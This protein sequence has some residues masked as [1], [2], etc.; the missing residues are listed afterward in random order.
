M[1]W[2]WRRRRRWNPYYNYRR[3]TR[4]RLY[5]R[6]RPRRI[7]RRKY[8]RYRV[9][10]FQIPKR[11]LKKIT[12]NEWQPK[13][14]K[15]CNIKGFMC[16]FQCA[17]GRESFNY[18]QYMKSTT[19]E[20]WPGGGGWSIM[21]YNLG[22]LW[23]QRELLHNHWTKSNE[24]LPLV[25]Y[26]GV[27]FTFYREDTVDYIVHWRL[28]YPMTDTVQEHIIAQPS[29]TYLMRNRLIVASKR[30]KPRSKPYIKKRLYPPAQMKSGWYFQRDICNIGFLLLTAT[31]ISLDRWFLNPF[32]QSDSITLYALNTRNF[33]SRNFQLTGTTNYYVPR[34]GYYL[35][36]S[37]NGNLNPAEI[38]RKELIYLGNTMDYTPGTMGSK[39]ADEFVSKPKMGNPF[40]HEYINGD[41]QVLVSNKDPKVLFNE[42]NSDDAKAEQRLTIQTNPTIIPVRYTPSKDTGE[43]NITYILKNTRQEE[44]WEPPQ[45]TNLI[46]QGYP[47]W[48]QLWGWFD[49]Q[50]KLKIA[51]QIDYNYIA[52]TRTNFFDEKLPAYVLLDTAFRRGTDPYY[53]GDEE[54]TNLS[55]SNRQHFYPKIMYQQDSYNTICQT[56]PG[57]VKMGNTSIE[58]KCKYNFHLKW[59]GC[60]AK[61]ETIKDPCEQPKYTI[62]NNQLQTIQMQ[63]PTT[64]P[65]HFLYE[66]DERRHELTKTAIERLKKDSQTETTCFYPT[67]TTLLDP[68]VKTISKFEELL[69][70]INQETDSEE[71]KTSLQEQL[72]K[73]HEQQL[74]LKH[75]IKQMLHRLRELE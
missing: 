54:H 63:S 27:T 23:E 60:P 57:V 67:E 21:I 71:E 2:I 36:A 5:R 41:K 9:R 49:W 56:G 48:A 46:I 66:W 6:R 28:C 74:K 14:I 22:A 70:E 32:S 25:R 51:Q 64:N 43:G 3:Y 35:Y 34:Q 55:A 62:P 65:Q 39:S 15:K 53:K 19:P 10:R 12:I 68:S 20:G 31:A 47:L 37:Y 59:G 8:R 75:Q 42:L 61:M 72:N 30:T 7:I 17:K 29:L 44:G 52:V 11:K 4:R 13:T 16:L 58:A 40:W 69:Q 26:N 1:P 50:K 38:K 73:Q 45:D 18:A 33:L 24:G